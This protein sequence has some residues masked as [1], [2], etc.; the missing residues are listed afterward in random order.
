MLG[1]GGLLGYGPAI[2]F[3]SSSQALFV[4]I[5]DDASERSR[6]LMDR[7]C[8]GN[9]W[10]M[11]FVYDKDV[12]NTFGMRNTLI[13]LSIAWIKADGTILEIEDMQ[14]ETTDSHASPEPYRYAI[15]ANQGWFT[16]HGIAAGDVATIPDN[17]SAS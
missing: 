9:D 4:E 8:L 10:G 12:Q 13:P 5:A 16:E 15:E 2:T 3:G 1:P 17:L 7:T 11:L 14:P 6:G